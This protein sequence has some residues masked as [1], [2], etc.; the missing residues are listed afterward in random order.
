M[1]L[2]PPKIKSVTVAVVSPS[3]CHEVTVPDA[4]IF[5]VVVVVLI[6]DTKFIYITQHFQGMMFY[7]VL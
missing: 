6:S 7:M 5:V 1:I 4:M 2:E 3:I